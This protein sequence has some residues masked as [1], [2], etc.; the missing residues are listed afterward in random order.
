MEFLHI[1]QR[2]LKEFSVKNTSFG[3]VFGSPYAFLYLIDG[4]LFDTSVSA[5]AYLLCEKL[6]D[7]EW[8]RKIFLTHSHYDHLGGV[9]TIKSFFPETL[10]YAN[11][12][13]SRVL[14]SPNALEIIKKFDHYDSSEI[15]QFHQINQIGFVT[16]ELDH[17]FDF[18]DKEYISIENIDVIYTPGHTKDT[19]SYYLSS[20]NCL[21][22]SE[23]MGIPNHRFD[24][25]L[26]E[27]LSS[28]NLY[29]QSFQKLKDLV[30]Q[31]KINNFL[32][33][34][35]MYFEYFSD[36]RDFIKLS[37]YSLNMYVKSIIGFIQKVGLDKNSIHDELKVKDVFRMVLD[38]YYV[39]YELSQPMYGFEANVTAQIRAI[40]KELL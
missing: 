4:L 33:P 16:F 11:S 40:V 35:I 26:P 6:K 32:L 7:T 17:T 24:F 18:S 12:Y 34:H 9:G 23:C 5:W 22:M 20:Y 25:V 39:K 14:K 29:I 10:V 13:V 36:V 37:E 27:F 15:K 8:K 31:K 38:S 19:V 3:I 28:Y 30:L 2:Y 21:I 1:R